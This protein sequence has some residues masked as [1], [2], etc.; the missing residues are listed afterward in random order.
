ML[1]LT[2]K[3]V[4]PLIEVCTFLNSTGIILKNEIRIAE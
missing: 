4:K 1:Q 2:E 3:S